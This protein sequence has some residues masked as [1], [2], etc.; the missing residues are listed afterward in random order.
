MVIEYEK[1]LVIVIPCCTSRPGIHTKNA[2]EQ[3]VI[4]SHR[5]QV[6]NVM[7]VNGGLQSSLMLAQKDNGAVATGRGILDSRTGGSTTPRRVNCASMSDTVVSA[8]AVR[9]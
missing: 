8:S 9:P 6:M 4:D 5:H 2:Y 1:L 3:K 7:L